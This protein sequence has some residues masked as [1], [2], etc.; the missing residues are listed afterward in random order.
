MFA[1]ITGDIVQSRQSAVEVWINLLKDILNQYG[2]SPKDWEIYRGDSFQIIT[3]PEQALNLSFIIKSYL[4]S[5]EINVRM[6]IGIGE[7]DYRTDKATESNGTAFVNSG[8]CFDALK[9]QT[10]ALQT[11]W[12]PL[13]TT[14]NIMLD[15]A[16]I[17]MD[18]WTAKTAE[19]VCFKF[20]N[21][22][23]NQKD[24][25]KNFDNKRQGNISEALKRG[26]YDELNQLLNYYQQS[27]RELC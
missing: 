12:N 4:K 24:I 10:L 13:N 11:P 15:L 16:T 5:K 8:T 18:K 6:A 20:Q 17:T 19:V 27:I 26:G 7:I 2:S 21:P 9:K 23:M 3:T 22:T 25:A 1:V 14:L